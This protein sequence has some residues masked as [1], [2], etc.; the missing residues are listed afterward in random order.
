MHSGNA[1]LEEDMNTKMFW[2]LVRAVLLVAATVIT[3]TPSPAAPKPQTIVIACGVQ[4]KPLLEIAQK[5]GY[6]AAEGLEV[7][8]QTVL[9]GKE[10]LEKLFSGDC[11]FAIP[12]ASPVAHYGL[13]RDDFRVIASLYHNNDINRI[14]ARQD[15]GIASPKDLKGKRIGVSPNTAPHFFVDLLLSKH[16][17][18]AKEVTWVFREG[19]A[20]AAL[21]A[22]DSADAIATVSQPALSLAKKLGDKVVLFNDPTICHN[23]I[24]VTAMRQTLASRPDVADRLLRALIKTEQYVAS[25]AEDLSR[26]FI[27]DSSLGEDEAKI[28]AKDY[29]FKV[30]LPH[31]LLLNLEEM[32]RWS[33]ENGFTKATRP[34]DSLRLVDPGPMRRVAPSAVTLEK[35][36]GR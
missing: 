1:K 12:G 13:L 11:D 22:D 23:N 36:G 5:Q 34:L 6:F 24:V 25:H 31:V 26:I 9:L 21:L 27:L 7:S 33:A 28:L 20:L 16:G 19:P 15:R 3:A 8:L 29:Y 14:V 17:I 35:T 18:N 10:A 32:A 4:P 2:G 30:G